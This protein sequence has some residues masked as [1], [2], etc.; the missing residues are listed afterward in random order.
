MKTFLRKYSIVL[1]V[2]IFFIPEITFCNDDTEFQRL[3][4]SFSE[5]NYAETKKIAHNLLANEKYFY[6]IMIILSEVYFQENDLDS[7]LSILQELLLKYPEKEYDIK[8]RLKRV[9]KEKVFLDK[10]IKDRNRKIEVFFSEESKE[11]NDKILEKIM[12]IF[13]DAIYR[14][15]KFFGWYPDFLIKVLVYYG[16]E[17]SDYT[18][19]PLWSLGGFDGKIRLKISRG[20]TENILREIVYHEYAH[21]VVDSITKKNCPLWLHE[22]IAQ[23]FS[24]K[25]LGILIENGKGIKSPD[26]FPKSLN[27]EDKKVAKI[28]YEDALNTVAY[29]INSAGEYIIY[30]LLNQLGTGKDFKNALN[31]SVSYLGL[32]FDVLFSQ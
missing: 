4:N 11:S 9:E 26:K 24:K 5:R 28:F 31:T 3:I 21:L 16:D 22:G 29:L 8:R 25:E 7:A 20:I 15:G 10:G 18:T 12:E 19:L 2:S 30:D 27:L 17:Y 1:F 6:P 23:F 32:S 14:G 13:D